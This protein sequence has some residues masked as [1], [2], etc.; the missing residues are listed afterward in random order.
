MPLQVRMTDLA[1]RAHY[2]EIAYTSMRF[3]VQLPDAQFTQFALRNP[4]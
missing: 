4:Q 3:D 1:E 2:T